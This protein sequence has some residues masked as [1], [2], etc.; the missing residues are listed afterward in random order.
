MAKTLKKITYSILEA[1]S[2]FDITDDNPFSVKMIEDLV[3]S[4]N[5][6]LLRKAHSEKR[7]D[8]MLY[9][10]DS[11]LQ[12]REFSPDINVSGLNVK[13]KKKLCYADLKPLVTGLKGREIDVVTN[14]GF[15]IV[16]TRTS[17]KELIRGSSGYYQINAHKYAL[18]NDKLVFKREEISTKVVSVNGIWSD[19]R[20]VS[21]WT[22]DTPFPTPSEKNIELLV[23]QHIG[24][25][26]GFPKDVINDAQ[27]ALASAPRQKENE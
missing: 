13:A 22:D 24:Q 16:F 27:E 18:L 12:L 5:H 2:S 4:M 3:I 21:S 17:L 11:N 14:A 20:L 8:E 15:S 10:I 23:V 26:L 6:T 19:P 25:A 9:L 1:I 7:I